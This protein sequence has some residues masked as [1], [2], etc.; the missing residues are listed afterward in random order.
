MAQGFQNLASATDAK[1]RLISKI[2]EEFGKTASPLLQ[3][4]NADGSTRAVPGVHVGI[5][6]LGDEQYLLAVHTQVASPTIMDRLRA[7]WSDFPSGSI[8]HRYVGRTTLLAQ[9]ASGP[10]GAHWIRRPMELGSCVGHHRATLSYGTAGA[11]FETNGCTAFLS[12]AHV[13]K[14]GQQQLLSRGKP[15]YGTSHVLQP[16]IAVGGTDPTHRV[17]EVVDSVPIDPSRWNF[18][19]AAVASVNPD[20]L[21]RRNPNRFPERDGHPIPHVLRDV[22]QI[23]GFHDDPDKL[24][25]WVPVEG[26]PSPG[27]QVYKLGARSGWT[28]GAVVASHYDLDVDFQKMGRVHFRN[29]LMVAGINGSNFAEFGDSGAGVISAEGRLVGIV[30]ACGQV[31]IFPG[32]GRPAYVIP[33]EAIQGYLPDLKLI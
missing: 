31:E 12:N 18:A 29:V 26:L 25:R 21:P 3:G 24:V 22:G 23:S 10:Q 2:A 11:F 1:N 15:T 17:G 14:R 32:S 7:A 33:S 13:L 30:F 27:Q 6:K 5:S 16:A 9:S 4:P 28:A 8:D 20:F 19:D